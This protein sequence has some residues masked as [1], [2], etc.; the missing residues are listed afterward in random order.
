MCA[1]ALNLKFS[2]RLLRSISTCYD[3]AGMV[4]HFCKLRIGTKSDTLIMTAMCCHENGCGIGNDVTHKVCVAES[5]DDVPKITAIF[6]QSNEVEKPSWSVYFPSSPWGDLIRYFICSQNSPNFDFFK[7][8]CQQVS[9][10]SNASFPFQR[11]EQILRIWKR[12]SQGLVQFICNL[13]TKEDNKWFLLL[14]LLWNF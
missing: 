9:M 8:G 7:F 12:V 4:D 5:N 14:L 1:I 3:D 6:V 2:D 10:L 13:E 11:P